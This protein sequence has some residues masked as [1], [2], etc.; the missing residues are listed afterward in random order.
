MTQQYVEWKTVV[1]LIFEDLVIL[2]WKSFLFKY[3]VA[4]TG[5]FDKA[6]F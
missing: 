3:L 4:V 5:E 6:I 2:S 1:K